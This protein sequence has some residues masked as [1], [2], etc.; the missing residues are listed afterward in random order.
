DRQQLA[1]DVFDRLRYAVGAMEPDLAVQLTGG[2]S[3]PEFRALRYLAQLAVNIVDYVDNDD[4]MTPFNWYTNA[5][6]SPAVNETVVGF[7]L[8]RVVINETYLQVENGPSD[9]GL[10]A[11]PKKA[12]TNY[13][14]K[15]WAELL[16]PLRTDTGNL[17][18]GGKAQ[19]V[20]GGSTTFPV[21][22]LVL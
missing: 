7:E 2:T 19:L 6:G 22:K 11:N 5:R 15:C 18:N 14:I 8:P 16:N 21:Y 1:R 3:T 13:V 4:V 17:S 12:T 20:A 9:P 10:T